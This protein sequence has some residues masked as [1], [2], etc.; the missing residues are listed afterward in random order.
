MF[1]LSTSGKPLL[2]TPFPLPGL[3]LSH[4]NLDTALFD[5]L[6][7][8]HT[9]L[10][11]AHLVS[12]SFIDSIA[13]N[14]RLVSAILEGAYLMDACFDGADL[15]HADL[16]WCIALG[17]SFRKARLANANLRGGDFK[18]V[19]FTGADLSGADLS[20]DNLGGGTELQGANLID[21]ILINAKL[22]GARYDSCTRFPKSFNP[23]AEGL[24]LVDSLA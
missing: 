9:D 2:E 5:G 15:S 14:T 18:H 19:N 17:A 23:L 10:S 20:K 11:G 24:I 16:Y 6:N 12:A 7:L 8:D 4:R 22:E 13:T 21:T 1:I 3:D